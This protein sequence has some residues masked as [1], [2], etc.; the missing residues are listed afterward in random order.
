MTPAKLSILVLEDDE[1]MRLQYNWLLSDYRILPAGDRA[2]AK[3]IIQSE[4][5]AIAIVDL[6]LPPDADGATEGLA[7]VSE[8]LEMA[9]E[10]KI[11]V[12]TGN[13]HAENA[14]KAVS[15]GA[16]DFFQK[17]VDPEI[18][19]LIVGRAARLYALERENRALSTS[20]LQAA[21]SGILGNSAI[22]QK[23]LRDV[24]RIAKSDA[25]VLIT[26]E[27]GTGKE[28]VASAIHQLSSRAKGPFVAINCA[29]IPDSLLEAEL[30]GHEKGA[31]TG[32]IRQT[33]GKIEQANGGTLF[34]DEIGDIPL[35]TQVKLLR[36]LEDRIIERVGGRKSIQIDARI[37]TATNQDLPKLISESQFREDLF[38]RINEIGIK[39]PA[40]RDRGEDIVLLANFFLRKYAKDMGRSFRGFS[41]EAASALMQHAW[42]GNVRELENR[43][44]R[45]A[46]MAEGSLVT[47]AD[48]DLVDSAD[49]PLATMREVRQRAERVALDQ[50]LARADG[51]LSK[52]AALLEISRPTLYELLE[53]HG[54]TAGRKGTV[55]PVPKRSQKGMPG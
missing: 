52:V 53:E 46:I 26:G 24:E 17:P 55:A 40:L 42:R 38:Y 8:I 1:G 41:K 7:A 47:V 13:E 15:S 25:S 54:L 31:F 29:A 21:K 10:T 34:L 9:A 33:N 2:E 45:A 49:A 16:Y 37:V 43:V 20:N 23:T 48:L 12:V 50:A 4:H 28:L 18:L 32:A 36:F 6:G 11:I 19:K 44:K 3:S 51:N 27:S 14:H 30:F 39:L 35:S 22:M 5:P